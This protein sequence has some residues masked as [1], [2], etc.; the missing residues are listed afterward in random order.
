MHP[1][2]LPVQPYL[3]PDLQGS[4]RQGLIG[5]RTDPKVIQMCLRQGIEPDIPEDPG[6]AEEI[7]ALQ[8]ARSRPLKDAHGELV[9]PI[10]VDKGSQVKF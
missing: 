5:Q 6:E 9:F 2:R 7:L 3:R 1:E 10:D 4:L 8:P